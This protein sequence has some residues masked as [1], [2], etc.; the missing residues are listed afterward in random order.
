MVAI[1]DE[2][3]R[4]RIIAVSRRF[5]SSRFLELRFINY[6]AAVGRSSL[7]FAAMLNVPRIL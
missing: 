5:V 3:Q 4:R 6:D 2:R 1:D 7:S